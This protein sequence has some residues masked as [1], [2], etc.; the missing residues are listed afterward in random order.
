MET[1]NNLHTKYYYRTQ[2]KKISLRDLMS[3][4]NAF[5]P[6]ANANQYFI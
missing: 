4:I 5:V 2:R 6:Y 3:G 1:R